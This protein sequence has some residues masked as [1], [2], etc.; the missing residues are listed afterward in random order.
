LP[1]Q[2]LN[3]HLHDT[4]PER[5]HPQSELHPLLQ[6]QQSLSQPQPLLSGKPQSQ[7]SQPVLPHPQS[8]Q[9]QLS[10]QSGFVHPQLFCPL[11]PQ[12]LSQPEHELPQPQPK[13]L[14]IIIFSL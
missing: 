9:P 4:A 8:E 6:E 14:K 3:L 12:S 10:F 5:R 13:F 7:H 2:P 11:H 1:K